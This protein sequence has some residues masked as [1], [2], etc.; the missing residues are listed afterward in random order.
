VKEGNMIK[1]RPD[2]HAKILGFAIL[3]YG[4]QVLPEVF[5]TLNRIREYL[6]DPYASVP[7]SAVLYDAVLESYWIFLFFVVSIIAGVSLLG[8]RSQSKIPSVLFTL[9]A[10]NLFPLGT[11]LS[12]YVLFYE[13]VIR[14]NADDSQIA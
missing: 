5:S 6:L 4:L 13:F 11:I 1:I 7:F 10:I 2:Q 3:G 12:L 9:C 14:D 8:V